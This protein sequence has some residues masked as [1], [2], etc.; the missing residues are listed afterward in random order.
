MFQVKEL[1]E[2]QVSPWGLCH[3]SP[4]TGNPPSAPLCYMKTVNLDNRSRLR[5]LQ[6]RVERR[7]WFQHLKKSVDNQKNA[8]FHFSESICQ[9]G[10]HSKWLSKAAR[11]TKEFIVF[12]TQQMATH[13]CLLVLMSRILFSHDLFTIP[14]MLLLF[15]FFNI[16][17]AEKHG[18]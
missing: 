5:P 14:T 18:I 6:T 4:I 13:L 10:S 15:F 9:R 8:L 11:L 2:Q 12:H 3:S 16:Q 1:F 7:L 17:I